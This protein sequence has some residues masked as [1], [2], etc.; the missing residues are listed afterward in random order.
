[1]QLS[2]LPTFAFFL[3]GVSS[4]VAA[5]GGYAATCN[6]IEIYPPGGNSD[7]YA[8]IGNC[9]KFDGTYQVGAAIQ[10]NACFV[11]IGGIVHFLLK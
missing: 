6:S 2:S 10:L 3:L 4:K 1:M 8:L 9:Q 7:T 11:N 5:N